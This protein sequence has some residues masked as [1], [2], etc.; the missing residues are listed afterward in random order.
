MKTILR[1]AVVSCAGTAALAVASNALATQRLAVSQTAT[2]V[3]IKVSQ[4]QS[5]PQPAKITTF[6]PA[7]YQ[8]NPSGAVGSTIGTATGQVFATDP[9]VNLA[10]NGSGDVL[11]ADESKIPAEQEAKCSPGPHVAVWDVHLTIFG[12]ALDLYVYVSPTSGAETAL[13]V[14]K[15]EVCLPPVDVPVGT[16]GRAPNGAKLLDATFTVNNQLTLPSGSQRWTSL[17][18]PYAAGTGQPDTAG[19]VEARSI[20]GPGAA[21]ILARVTNRKLKLLRIT[22]R[23]TQSG[24]P[25]PKIHVR[26]MINSKARFSTTTGSN[27]A[28]A[29]HLRNTRPRVTTSF[30]QAVVTVAARDVTGTQCA[31]PTPGAKCVSAT[32]GAFTARSRKVRVRL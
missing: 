15:L 12:Q 14:A 20:V 7:G 19:T 5:D 24:V 32:A 30:F 13:G 17:W 3:T 8:L 31:N 25:V 11:V 2:G 4:D 27:G 22:G 26:L 29:F 23:V 10:L 21:S 6:V 16:P 1:L 9:N 28:Y 18:I